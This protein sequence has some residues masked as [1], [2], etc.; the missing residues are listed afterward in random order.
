MLFI[1]FGK[2]SEL[3]IRQHRAFPACLNACYFVK[4]RMDTLLL[5]YGATVQYSLPASGVKETAV[6]M[7]AF[8]GMPDFS[9]SCWPLGRPAATKNKAL[10]YQYP[11]KA[12]FL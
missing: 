2:K 9:R 1:C 5:A 4:W 7:D 10:P 12:L 6:R 11:Q 3:K 8:T